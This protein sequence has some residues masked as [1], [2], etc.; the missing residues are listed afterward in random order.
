MG[1]EEFLSTAFLLS[2]AFFGLAFVLIVAVLIVK[3][4]DKRLDRKGFYPLKS[5]HE[6]EPD[7]PPYPEDA[8]PDPWEHVWEDD[9]QRH[10]YPSN[11]DRKDYPEGS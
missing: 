2:A 3:R 10:R 8:P 1:L 9:D 11:Q 6:H 5:K 4:F 7:S